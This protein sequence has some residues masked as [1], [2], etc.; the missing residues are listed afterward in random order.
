MDF[1]EH[2][3]NFESVPHTPFFLFLLIA[4]FTQNVIKIGGKWAFFENLVIQK[5]KNETFSL[6]VQFL[7]D[8]TD[9]NAD[10]CVIIRDLLFFNKKVY[11]EII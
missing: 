5:I 8:N 1:Q 7:N 2:R 10:F 6:L 9:D 3:L 11:A 4:K